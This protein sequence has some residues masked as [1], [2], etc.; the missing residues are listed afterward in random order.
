VITIGATRRR[1]KKPAVRR[2]PA[3]VPVPTN[4]VLDEVRLRLVPYLRSVYTQVAK[5]DT[6]ARGKFALRWTVEP[7]GSVKNLI[8]VEDA[9]PSPMLKKYV[10]ATVSRWRFP[11]TGARSELAFP[12]IFA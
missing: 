6:G 11:A 12:F 2:P 7:D 4:P 5:R 9:L 8:V 10:A 3:A 1:V